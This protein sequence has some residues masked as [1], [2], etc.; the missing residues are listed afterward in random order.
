MVLE[1]PE[2]MTELLE[3]QGCPS[4]CPAEGLLQEPGGQGLGLAG[5]IKGVGDSPVG[6]NWAKERLGFF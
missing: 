2:S 5:P 4:S 3:V 6:T 1:K